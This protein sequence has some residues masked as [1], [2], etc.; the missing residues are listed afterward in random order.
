ML[1]QLTLHADYS[2]RV[3]LYLGSQPEGHVI[4]EGNQ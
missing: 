3:L 4:D 2:F 1:V